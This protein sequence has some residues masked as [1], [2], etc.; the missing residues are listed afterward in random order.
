MVGSWYSYG[1]SSPP[2]AHFGLG[3]DVG[4]SVEVLWPDGEREHF[5]IEGVNREVTL[6]QGKGDLAL[7]LAGRPTDGTRLQPEAQRRQRDRD[8]L[9]VTDLGIIPRP[10]VTNVAEARLNQALL[11]AQAAVEETP[12]AETWGHLGHLYFLH[13]WPGEGAVCYLNAVDLEPEDFGWR[14]FLGR[15]YGQTDAARAIDAYEEAIQLDPG[16]VAAYAYCARAMR[17]LGRVKEAQDCLERGHEADPSDP[18]VALG[19]GQLHLGARRYG[20]AQR[21]LERALELNPERGETHA[22]LSQMYMAQGDRE[23]ARHHAELGARYFQQGRIRDPLFAA[24]SRLG[25]SKYWFRHRGKR[26]LQEGDY[27]G[28]AQEYGQATAEGEEDPVIWSGYGAALLGLGRRAEAAQAL[29]RAL[30]CA[31]SGPYAGNVLPEDLRLIHTNIGHAYAVTG[32]PDKAEH[33]LRE[34]LRLDPSSASAA[35]NLALVYYR[36]GRAALAL[37]A[38]SSVPE[39]EDHPRALKLR[40]ALMAASASQDAAPAAH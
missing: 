27:A 39:L 18:T 21:H 2:R 35:F 28:A 5:A 36:G 37:D 29:E 22:A 30:E 10:D 11:A 14:Y 24:V 6:R 40:R 25:V 23:A 13:G 1:S 9:A 15:A 32:Q 26:R 19:L 31:H 12:S 7:P 20:E 3:S 16:Y 17:D 4:N 33:H 8:M 38:L 34:A